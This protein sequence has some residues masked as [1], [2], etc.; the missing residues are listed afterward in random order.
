MVHLHQLGYSSTSNKIAKKLNQIL[1]RLWHSLCYVE[2]CNEWRG[3]SPGLI[4]LGQHS[5]EET[6]Q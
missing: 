3:P 1:T 2:V 4:A 5:S 6:S